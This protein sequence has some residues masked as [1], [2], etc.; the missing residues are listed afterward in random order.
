[1]PTGELATNLQSA[2]ISLKKSDPKGQAD[3]TAAAECAKLRNN[4]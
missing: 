1:M 2:A 3:M 4:R